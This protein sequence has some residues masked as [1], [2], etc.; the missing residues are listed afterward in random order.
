MIMKGAYT[1]SGGRSFI[2]PD[3]AKQVESMIASG[4]Y[5]LPST[6]SSG[7]TKKKKDSGATSGLA[8]GVS[9]T[10]KQDAVALRNYF[11]KEKGYKVEYIPETGDI[12]VYDPS[13]GSSAMV[14]HG[15]YSLSG[16]SAYITPDVVKQV[17]NLIGAG[18]Y[19]YKP[20]ISEP[21]TEP[22]ATAPMPY[23]QAWQEAVE[24]ATSVGLEPWQIDP[25]YV[26]AKAEG[27]VEEYTQK[28][29]QK[30]LE[31]RS[32]YP[33]TIYGQQQGAI[34]YG[35][36]ADITSGLRNLEREIREADVNTAPLYAK[37][38]DEYL[39]LIDKYEAQLIDAYQKQMG[40][41]DP[42][43][44]LALASLKE[45][46][47]RQRE[48]LLEEMSRR[49]LLH[50]GLWLEAEER[51]NRGELTAQQ[52][53][54]ASRLSDL[55]N[56]LNQALMNFT[57]ARLGAMRTY[58]LE[59]IQAAE[60]ES[61]ARQQQLENELQRALDEAYRRKM[62]SLQEFQ[63]YAPYMQLTEL[64]RQTLPMEWS[65]LAGEV[66]TGPGTEN[67]PVRSYVGTSGT[68]GYDSS[69]GEVIING[70]RVKP[71]DVGGYI[72]AG[73]AYLPRNVIDDILRRY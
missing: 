55:Q 64:Q 5:K 31:A 62:L 38:L 9:S 36:F 27:R 13:T 25:E 2:T 66:A 35:D 58:G 68:V 49:G 69:T 47:K 45:T 61:L 73:T 60:R 43:T 57:S 11:E 4:K 41:V 51:L 70:V 26:K 48:S 30:G 44:I 14:Q 7:S 32:Q 67:V 3:V 24:E 46:V 52:Q 16:G 56:Q 29:I 15:A 17:E 20:A 37:A 63:T 65:Q 1:E 34:E 39:G 22:S 8:S 40:G 23:E 72:S 12:R 33:V 42:A 50:S 18:T 6:S 10:T 53:I 21:V 71:S 19:K 54:L 59:G 28:A